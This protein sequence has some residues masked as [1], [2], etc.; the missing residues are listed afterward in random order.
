MSGH[1]TGARLIALLG[2]PGIGKSAMVRNTM[3]YILERKLF[4]G[5][6][7][8]INLK[9]A[10]SLR[11]LIKKLKKIMIQALKLPFGIKRDTLE[12]AEKDKFLEIL[13]RFFK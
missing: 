10:K 9:N 13:V 2:L 1:K 12:H 11:D 5:G 4:L 6:I 3:H 8:L 7:M